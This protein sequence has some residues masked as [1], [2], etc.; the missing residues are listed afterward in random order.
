M[1]WRI[2]EAVVRGE[3]DNRIKG[4]VT[5]KN[6]TCAFMPM[7]SG[8]ISGRRIFP[9]TSSLPMRTLLMKKTI[10]CPR[11]RRSCLRR[12][13]LSTERSEF[14]EIIRYLGAIVHCGRFDH[15]HIPSALPG[16]RAGQPT[17]EGR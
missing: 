4:S 12:R 7:R 17:T 8:A 3:I 14:A 6:Y 16:G 2:D 15:R 9:R 13:N 11:L 1:A 5:G 10:C